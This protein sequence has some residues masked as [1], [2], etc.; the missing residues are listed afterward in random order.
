M[1]PTTVDE[2][3]NGFSGDKKTRLLELRKIV[4]ASLPNTQEAIKWGD[5]AVLDQ[6]GMILASYGAFKNHMNLVVTPSTKQAFEPRLTEYTTGKGSVQLPYDKPLPADLIKEILAYRLNEY[7]T[8][9]VKWI[10]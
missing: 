7:R 3:I 9:G 5:P 2:Y 6:D 4:Q 8:S 10:S 1:K